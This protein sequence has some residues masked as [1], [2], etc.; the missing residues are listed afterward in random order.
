MD[1]THH[2]PHLSFPAEWVTATVFLVA[3]FG[4]GSMI[5]RE[6]RVTRPA[7]QVSTDPAAAAGAVP[8]DAVSVPSLL[9]GG[10]AEIQVGESAASAEGKL[11]AATLA[12]RSVGRG[13]VGDREV[14]F[15]SL[16]GTRF[17]VVFEP[18]ERRGEPRVASIYLR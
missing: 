4:V 13:P 18:F 7:V 16:A 3:T 11:A 12:G 6:L 1:A 17:I 10:Q 8:E 9:L 5:V 2:H 15:Y 14:R